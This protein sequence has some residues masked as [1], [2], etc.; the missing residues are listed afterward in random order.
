MAV[1]IFPNN[2]KVLLPAAAIVS[3]LFLWIWCAAL[4]TKSVCFPTCAL[5]G[6]EE[7][8]NSIGFWGVICY[9]NYC[10]FYYCWLLTISCCCSCSFRC[11]NRFRLMAFMKFLYRLS[12]SSTVEESCRK[13]STRKRKKQSWLVKRWH[14]R[15]SVVPL[16]ESK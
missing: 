10:L 6:T 11:C 5:H 7:K 15:S 16:N 2:W 4:P 9:F 1:R 14:F 3:G 13:K 12:S 8:Q